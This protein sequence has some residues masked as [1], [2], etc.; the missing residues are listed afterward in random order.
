MRGCRP[1]SQV[2]RMVMSRELGVVCAG[3]FPPG[4]PVSHPTCH[5]GDNLGANLKSVSH[6]CHPILVAFAW[7]LTKE[8]TYLPLGCLQGGMRQHATMGPRALGRQEPGTRALLR[9][10]DP[11]I[12]QLK[13]QGP[14]RT[15]GESKDEDS[16]SHPP[17]IVLGGVR[18]VACFVCLFREDRR[19]QPIP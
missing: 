10:I 13:A 19:C 18:S 5:P 11:C 8:T 16:L 14:S 2:G 9:L 4:Q 15:C 17:A 7:E 6:R 1:R 3:R 12:T